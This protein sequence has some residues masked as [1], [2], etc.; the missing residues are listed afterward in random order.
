MTNGGSDGAV[1]TG[2]RNSCRMAAPS[3]GRGRRPA[4]FG[5]KGSV[6]ELAGGTGWWTERL[7]R[8]AERLPVVDSSPEAL[9]LN[10]ARVDAPMSTT[11]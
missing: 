10:Q 2:A 8:T 1:M 7:A 11:S 5:A 6:L 9:A 4:S 3:S